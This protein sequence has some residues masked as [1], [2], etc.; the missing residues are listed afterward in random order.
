MVKFWGFCAASDQRP[1][2]TVSNSSDGTGCRGLSDM[3]FS[4]VVETAQHHPGDVLERCA[5]RIGLADQA[6]ALDAGG[7][8]AGELHHVGIGTQLAALLGRAERAAGGCFA[9]SA[10]PAPPAPRGA[11]RAA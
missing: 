2:P 3:T 9:P 7:E 10:G 6:Q 5:V 11:R 1:P 4:S 8:K